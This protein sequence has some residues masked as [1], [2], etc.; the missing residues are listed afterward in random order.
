MSTFTRS[1]KKIPILGPLAKKIYHQISGQTTFTNSS[2]YWEKRYRSGGDSGAGSYNIL[3]EYKAEIINEF[4]SKNNIQNIIEFGCGDGNQL[5]YF[6]F[7][8]YIGVDVSATVVQKCR[9]TYQSDSS[10]KF[11]VLSEYQNEGAEMSMSLDVIYHLVEDSIYLDYM[12]K[13]F[14]AA[15]Q[16]VIVYS[17]N[18]DDHENN[19]DAEHVRHR[20]FTSWVEKN[21][22]Q[23]ELVQHI[24]NQYPYNGNNEVSSYADFYFFRK[25]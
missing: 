1:I 3:A 13:L 2:D 18:E 10:K 20:K 15:G 9:N 11:I 16:Y 12:Q 17:S 25:K 8:H 19:H 24:P 14:A 22:P 21:A 5:K 6:H 4:V 7:P 23:F